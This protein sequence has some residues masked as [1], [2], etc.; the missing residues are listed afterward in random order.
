MKHTLDVSA[1]PHI[2]RVLE[3]KDSGVAD[4]EGSD[5]ARIEELFKNLAHKPLLIL[6]PNT[7]PERF[8]RSATLHCRV[9]GR[10]GRHLVLCDTCNQGLP[11]MVFGAAAARTA[12]GQVEMSK[13][14]PSCYDCTR[15]IPCCG[16]E[17]IPYRGIENQHVWVWDTIFPL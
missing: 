8:N 15:F 11:S 9:C 10:G 12:R 17:I 7:H 4:L 2:L 6:D 13:A 14:V 3:V 16:I 5:A 1:R